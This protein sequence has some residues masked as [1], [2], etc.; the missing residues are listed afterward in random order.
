MKHNSIFIGRS[1]VVAQRGRVLG[2]GIRKHW[3][4]LLY[5]EFV[6]YDMTLKIHIAQVY[7]MI[8]TKMQI[9]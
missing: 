6:W 2:I 8:T 3:S 7:Y 1:C 4:S 9:T 5:V